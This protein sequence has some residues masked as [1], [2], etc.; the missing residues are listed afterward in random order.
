M[1]GKQWSIGFYAV[2]LEGV[3]SDLRSPQGQ[4]R[5]DRTLLQVGEQVGFHDREHRELY[6]KVHRLNPKTAS[7]LTTDGLQWRVAYSLLFRVVEV[8]GQCMPEPGLIEGE[9]LRG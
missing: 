6:G 5:L 7:I 3:N 8:K 9:V 2:N 1:D 4:A